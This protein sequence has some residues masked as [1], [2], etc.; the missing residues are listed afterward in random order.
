MD[1]LSPQMVQDLDAG[2]LLGEVESP[3]VDREA[4]RELYGVPHVALEAVDDQL[5][6][7]SHPVLLSP[8]LYNREHLDLLEFIRL[9]RAYKTHPTRQQYNRHAPRRPHGEAGF[10][11]EQ[12]V[13]GPGSRLVLLALPNA[14]RFCIFEVCVR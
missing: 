11:C 2:P 4:Y 10:P 14:R 5:L 6:A 12:Q 9:R 3:F 13:P 8:A 7:L 1:L